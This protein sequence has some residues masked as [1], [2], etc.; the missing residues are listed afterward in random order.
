MRETEISWHCT[1][2][3]RINGL[4]VCISFVEDMAAWFGGRGLNHQNKFRQYLTS[5]DLYRLGRAHHQIKFF[6]YF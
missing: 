4:D 1:S 6:Q 2:Q 5:G 3:T